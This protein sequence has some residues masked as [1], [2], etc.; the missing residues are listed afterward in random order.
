MKIGDYVRII[1]NEEV[2]VGDWKIANKLR[3]KNWNKGKHPPKKRYVY[4]Q[5]MAIDHDS[6]IARV[7]IN[8]EDYLVGFDG[9]QKATRVRNRFDF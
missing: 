1:N 2:Y 8:H 5:I 9:L 6:E 4:G 3:C 7:S